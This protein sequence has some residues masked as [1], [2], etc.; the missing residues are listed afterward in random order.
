MGQLSSAE[1][2]DSPWRGDHLGV[3]FAARE[4]PAMLATVITGFL[5]RL[6][7]AARRPVQMPERFD[8]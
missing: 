1:Y 6:R 8:F 3:H 4:E 7:D 2:G 5:Q